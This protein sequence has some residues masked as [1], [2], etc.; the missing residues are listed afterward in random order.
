MI[1]TPKGFSSGP[2]LAATNAATVSN[3]QSLGV[4]SPKKVDGTQRWFFGTTTKL[5]ESSSSG[6]TLTDRSGATYNAVDP[7]QTWSFCQFGD[8]TLASNKGDVLQQINA[9]SAF[10]DVSGAPKASIIINAGPPTAPFILALNFYTA[11]CGDMKDGI[12]N[13]GLADYTGWTTGTNQAAT[14]QIFEPSGAIVAAIPY[15]DGAVCWKNGSMFEL[16]YSAAA[17]I[18]G[19]SAKR[20]ATDV[21]CAGKNMCVSVN[22]VIYFADKHGIWMYDGSYPKKV[23]GYF[24][25]FWATKVAAGLVTDTC[26]M[27]FD[28]SRHNL[29]LSY[30]N[31]GASNDTMNWLVWNQISNLW[32]DLGPLGLVT[33]SKLVRE[34]FTFEPSP[35]ATTKQASSGWSVETFAYDQSSND[36]TTIYT[37]PTMTLWNIG[38]PIGYTTVERIAPVWYGSNTPSA[39]STCVLAAKNSQNAA[40]IQSVTGTI[41]SNSLYLDAR[42]SANWVQPTLKIYGAYEFGSVGLS[43][44]PS[45]QRGTR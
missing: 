5:Y 27:R 1:P 36:N 10:A 8:V 18:P 39:L 20:I 28:P 43:V 14:F 42:L 15:R 9:G 6:G 25:D 24:H 35:L 37:P 34:I 16:N 32:A 21:G 19:W 33:N 41:D 11:A 7:T 17:T 44:T 45:G 26:Q 22:D 40:T 4:F 23:P 30:S 3:T 38:D 29:W 13:S 31:A 2:V 12:F